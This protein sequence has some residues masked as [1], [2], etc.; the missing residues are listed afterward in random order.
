M[1]QFSSNIWYYNK[2]IKN[3]IIGFLNIF[4]QMKV[5]TFNSQTGLPE[6]EMTV[7]ILFGPIERSSYI[8]SK[9]E[10]VQR[11]IQMPLLHFELTGMEHDKTRA[12]AEKSLHMQ[13][14]RSGTE[15]DVLMPW[16]VNFTITMNIYAKYQE[17]L[18]QLV[19]QIYPMFNYHRTYYTKHPIFPE[20]ITLSHWVSVTTPPNFAF[21][22]EYSAEQRRDILSVPIGFTIESWMVREAYGGTGIIKEII[23]NF[24][25]YDTQKGLEQVRLL[26]D[27][28]IRDLYFT[29]DSLYF[30]P[31]LGTLI[32]G[33]YHSAYIVDMPEDGHFIVKFGDEKHVF[34]VNET[35]RVGSN[36]IGKTISC[37][38]YE[39]FKEANYGWSGYSNLI[40]RSG[41]PG[42]SGWTGYSEVW[43]SYSGYSEIITSS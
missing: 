18:M 27:P 37:E 4:P 6:S 11:T 29:P 25:D 2:N 28:T 9:G 34:L 22:Y 43:D 41:Y 32:S 15:Y 40:W 21:N 17:E 39:P 14:Q 10:T 19:E 23:A 42:P 31:T 35:L 8:N 5:K 36:A 12:F 1:L 20:E 33:T 24:I 38:P 30:A 26:A 7:P 3:M 13:G 16:P